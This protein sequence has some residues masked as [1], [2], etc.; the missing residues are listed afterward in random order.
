MINLTLPLR[1]DYVVFIKDNISVMQCEGSHVHMSRLVSLTTIL[2]RQEY[3]FEVK[4]LVTY[5]W[6]TNKTLTGISSTF[7]EIQ[8]VIG[9][10]VF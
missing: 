2:I 1:P 5:V 7:V 4:G 9:Q 3:E 6:K 8:S 10:S